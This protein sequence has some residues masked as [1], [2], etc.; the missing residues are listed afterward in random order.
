MQSHTT[1]CSVMQHADKF[2]N[3]IAAEI[4]PAISQRDSHLGSNF[5]LVFVGA[6]ASGEIGLHYSHVNML[7]S[8]TTL[9]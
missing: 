5:R 2:L 8:G 1:M 3:C 7:R 6:A 9:C 4:Q